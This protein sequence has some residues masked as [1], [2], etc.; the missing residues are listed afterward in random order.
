MPAEHKDT[1]L[2]VGSSLELRL[3]MREAFKNVY[4]LLEA[5]TVEQT[6]MFL[7]NNSS[8]IALVLVDMPEI[9]TDEINALVSAVGQGTNK[10]IPLVLLANEEIGRELEEKALILGVTDVILK[11]YSELTIRR[12]I[13][14]IADLFMHKQNLEDLV[15]EQNVTIRNANQVMMDT[16][17]AI[18]EYRSTESGNHVLRIRRFT[19]I[20]LE[21]VM[22]SCPEYELDEETIEMISSA[23]ALHDIGKISIPD[24]ILNK[25]GK[26][27]AEEFEAMKTHT[28]IGST[29]VK[30][31]A[32]MGEE[33]YLR[34][35]YNISLYH[36]ER[37]D[38]KGYPYGLAGDDIPV[39][40]QVVGLTD[41]FDALTTKRV[42]KP[43]FPYQQAINMILNGE[44]G[45]FSP[46]LLECFKHVR[47]KFVDLAYQYADGLS[48]K[49]D[50]ITVPLPAPKWQTSSLNTL[51]LLHAKQQALL[52]YIDDTILELDLDNEIYHVVYSP[53]PTLA[54]IVP[55]GPFSVVIDTLR[56]TLA[57]PED[58]EI[59]DE[60]ESFVTDELFRL[61]LRR[62]SFRLRI[63]NG[64]TSVYEPYELVFIRVDTGNSEH[65]IATGIWHRLEKDVVLQSKISSFHESPALYGL[66]SSA[67]RCLSDSSMTINEGASELF[68]LTGFTQDEIAEQFDNSFM[69]MIVSEDY[70]VFV[71]AMSDALKTGDQ[72]E[73]EFRLKCKEAEPVWVLA[74]GRVH[75]E[76]DG[77]EYFYL[78]IRD[79]SKTKQLH[80]QLTESIERSETIIEE[81]GAIIFEWNL[82]EDTM[83]CSPKWVDHFGYE[84][85]S[86]NYAQKLGIATHFHPDD[87][88]TVGEKIIELREGTPTVSF[89]VRIANNNGKYLWTR[90]T[91]TGIRDD[92]NNLTKI[93]GILQDIDEL[94][95]ATIV[96]K[97]EAERDALTKLLNKNTARNQIS[98][99]LLEAGADTKGGMIVIDLDNFKNVNDTLGHLYGDVVLK[100]VGMTLSKIFRSH[101]IIGRIGGDEFVVFLKDIPDAKLLQ[102]RCVLLVETLRALFERIVPDIN[103]SCS[104]GA[105]MTPEHGTSYS[106]VFKHADEAMYSVKKTGKNDY[107]IYDSKIKYTEILDVKLRNT[108]IDSD[109]PTVATNSSFER[110]VFNVLYESKDV[111]ATVNELLAF[112]GSYFGVSRAYVFEN[113]EDNTNC[114]NTFEW[115]NEGIEPQIDELQNISYIDDIPGWPD[116]Y[117]DK[118]ILYCTD[119]SELAPQFRAILEPQGIK[120]MLQCAILEKGVFRGYVG[121]DEC[122][123]NR[124]WTDEQLNQLEFLARILSV[125]LLDNKIK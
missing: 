65:R 100:N 45:H 70:K 79:N 124:L 40:A 3:E 62:R 31:L 13:S 55:T 28:T 19:K 122:R 58:K 97:E 48:P 27:T 6:V 63:F 25:P 52:Q 15:H 85:V 10:E 7:S 110:F 66:V 76:A 112:V 99:Y 56:K 60:M 64:A 77:R 83:Y 36:H 8:Y 118:G 12:R 107:T 84:P 26:L 104:I 102:D 101:D 54:S 47:K 94:K 21:E 74:K 95:R 11:P 98:D 69:K 108:R 73:T 61:K 115:C 105:A 121:F 67:I 33:M 82:I 34:Y 23:A 20:L 103:V 117:D 111:E 92:K 1:L 44:S 51:Q 32:S 49:S 93:I 87:T 86:E 18:I 43:A 80:H 14:I 38:G 59:L 17:S 50:N 114:S 39:C 9:S 57:H 123:T 109:D 46:K 119:I 5:E 71:K 42:Y 88:L 113:S 96:M 35:A 30:Q 106:E 75:L 37:W 41:V 2:I 125:F 91:A 89:D 53:N 120:S 29:L 72:I 4:N 68:V 90:I 22:R 78:A 116:V 24:S 81:S 16:L